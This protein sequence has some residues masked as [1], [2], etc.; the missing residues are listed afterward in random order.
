MMEAA[1]ICE[2]SVNYYQTTW[3]NIPEAIFILNVVRA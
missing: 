2:T 3:H 1:S